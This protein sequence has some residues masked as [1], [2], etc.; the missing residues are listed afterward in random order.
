MLRL[1]KFLAQCGLGSRR[2]CDHL[3]LSGDI[4]VNNAVV[5]TLGVV[6]DENKD[7]IT[8]QGNRV[9]KENA[10]VCI[11]LNKPRGYVTTVKDDWGRKIVTELISVHQRIFPIGR[12][13]KDTEGLLLLTNDGDL[14]FQ[15]THPKF[16]IEKEYEVTIEKDIS[17]KDISKLEQ[18]VM[19]EAG[20]TA[21]CRVHLPL[22]N[23]RQ[24][25]HIVLHEGKK[26]QVREML[27]SLGYQVKR[28]IRV[29]IA[30]LTINDVA[31]GNWRYLTNQEILHLKKQV[32]DSLLRR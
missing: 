31:V 28:L 17:S 14:C 32:S 27:K 4:R 22:K 16:F 2:Q 26:R 13:D 11:L 12:L 24:V 23:N 8:Y 21:P 6:I 20:F 3:I 7:Q 29:R 25:L 30:N 19:I 1:N 5:T 18:G 15:L 10:Q 9:S